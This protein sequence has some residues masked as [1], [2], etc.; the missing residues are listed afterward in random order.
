MKRVGLAATIAALSLVAVILSAQTAVLL[1]GP[2]GAQGPTGAT[3]AAGPN[4]P[5]TVGLGLACGSNGL[6]LGAAAG[7]QRLV[8]GASA[9]RFIALRGPVSGNNSDASRVAVQDVTGGTL[10]VTATGP[11]TALH[12]EDTSGHGLVAGG[13]IDMSATRLG[14]PFRRLTASELT[15]GN[16]DAVVSC[17]GPGERV[18]SGSCYAYAAGTTNRVRTTIWDRRCYASGGA[19]VDPAVVTPNQFLCGVSSQ[20][21]AVDIYAEA[22]CWRE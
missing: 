19:C 12:I 8:C 15:C 14:V 10:F 9:T 5:V 13:A 16:C 2:S 7:G 17:N 3:G 20:A 22:L 1:T 18:L 21:P 4:G 6:D 11:R